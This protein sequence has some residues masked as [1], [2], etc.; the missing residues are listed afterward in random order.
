MVKLW[1]WIGFVGMIMGSGIFGLRAVAMRRKVGIEFPLQTFFITLWAA[2][3]YLAMALG[4]TILID[5]NGQKE[6]FI[7][8]Y[9]DWLVTTPLLLLELGVIA[10]LSSKILLNAVGIDLLMILAGLCAT[11]DKAP[12][13]YIWYMVGS[14][15]FILIL[16]SLLT[17]FSSS[18][19]RRNNKVNKL[20]Q[21]L[22][23]VLI[24][25]WIFYPIVWIIG[26]GGFGIINVGFQI[27]LYAILDLSAKVG[28]GLIV[29]SAS[30]ETLAQASH[31]DRIVENVPDYDKF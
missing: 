11:L 6:I 13:K 24:A 3:M 17:E 28:F 1:L 18:A 4:E 21:T 19:R 2:V 23:N 25:S 12:N 16:T 31:S 5:F 27:G 29:I 10:G 20:F 30:N 7:G 15:C 26:P 9:L 14:G 22:R 8:R